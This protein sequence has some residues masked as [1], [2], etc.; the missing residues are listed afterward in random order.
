MSFEDGLSAHLKSKAFDLDVPEPEL[1]MVA[2]RPREQSR[3]GIML[4][5]VAA[6]VAVAAFGFLFVSGSSPTVTEGKL[7]DIPFAA[8]VVPASVLP[9]ENP[10]PQV[11]P[12][13][14][15]LDWTTLPMRG[16]EFLEFHGD[17]VAVTDFHQLVISEDGSKLEPLFESTV[18]AWHSWAS[19]GDSLY[20]IAAPVNETQAW[21][22]FYNEFNGPMWAQ[23]TI[24]FPE[25]TDYVE[26]IGAVGGDVVVN[27]GT[28]WETHPRQ[29]NL[30]RI[31]SD[32]HPFDDVRFITARDRIYV[33][34]E[35]SYLQIGS[36]EYE[37]TGMTRPELLEEIGS[38]LF[39]PTWATAVVGRSGTVRD[40]TPPVYDSPFFLPVLSSQTSIAVPGTDG[41]LLTDD[42][43]RWESMP[44]TSGDISEHEG[45]L[46]AN[47]FDRR[48]AVFARY[49]DGGWEEFGPPVEAFF[50]YDWLALDSVFD[51]G[52]LGFASIETKRATSFSYRFEFETQRA[53]VAGEAGRKL[54]TITKDGNT[55]E[56]RTCCS[57][58]ENGVS[59]RNGSLVFSD[60]ATS[61]E[62]LVIDPHTLER[63]LY[64]N[65]TYSNSSFTL[66]FSPDGREW[67]Q[68]PLSEVTNAEFVTD[69]LV[70]DRH[71]F[72]ATEDEILVGTP[73]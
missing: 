28:G 40:L 23:E 35:L 65:E 32:Y 43:Q 52:R 5:T 48:P 58:E 15:S 70:T 47:Q 31:L 57:D 49:V 3:T 2:H 61:T 13:L 10:S 46:F 63:N 22:L 71:V 37:A 12:L 25:G 73:K 64:G 27:Y 33:V 67:F 60:P 21:T 29:A 4:S 55:V 44:W 42:L 26:V 50:D 30:R 41:L 24:D 20:V 54:M 68:L 1:T 53:T 16:A 51:V 69:V 56:Y 39:Q 18:R 6:G 38:S 72:I 59:I 14:E 11:L 36:I 34:E 9:A 66:V 8:E 45:T 7:P 17:V 19:D 62:L